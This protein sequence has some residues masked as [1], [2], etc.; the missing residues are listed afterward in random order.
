MKI[1]LVRHGETDWNKEKMMQGISDI[2]LNET[3]INQA[4]AA[5]EK[6][7]GMKFDAVYASTLDRAITTAS[8]IGGV[9]KSEVIQ[10]E[11]I[12]E[13]NF[14]K[15]EKR[16]YYLMG[17]FMTLHWALPELIPS[18]KTVEKDSYTK[19]RANAFLA[20]LKKQNYEKVLIVSHGNFI[21]VFKHI[22][23]ND[24]KQA[25]WKDFVENC[26]ILEFEI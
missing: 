3:G 11:R 4:K 1:Y 24:G 5:R 12:I 8:I 23:A 21:R 10:D 16:N 7:Q 25:T 18:P 17:P 6:I 26:T 2:P 13:V 22:L 9:D 15:Y 19:E 20:D 14:G